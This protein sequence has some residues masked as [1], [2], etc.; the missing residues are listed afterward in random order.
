MS[1]PD[2]SADASPD[3]AAPRRGLIAAL[4][5]IAAEAPPEGLSLSELG[6]RL[7]ERAFGVM[8]FILAIPVCMPFLYGVP[9]IVALP[10]MA[11]AL[12]MAA[13]RD[14]PWM[15]AKFGARRLSLAS[16]QRTAQ[17]ARKWFGWI[18]MLARPR[19][20]VLTGPIGERV[21][22]VLFCGVLHLDPGAA[23]DHQHRAGHRHR[24]R[25]H[26]PDHPRRA[27]FYWPGWCWAWAGSPC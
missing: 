8:L 24:H 9:Q 19:L 16:L 14:Q 7:N 3:A 1:G 21:T 10:M 18:E 27:G 15:P 11:L 13:G 12:Q 5:V 23:A 26:R 20:S 2:A 17:G 22:G 6:A 25:R 4:E